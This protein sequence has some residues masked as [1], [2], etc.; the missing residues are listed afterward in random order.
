MQHC[1]IGKELSAQWHWCIYMYL[2]TSQKWVKESCWD[3]QQQ[4]Y[5]SF[6]Y[7]LIWIDNAWFY[8]MLIHWLKSRRNDPVPRFLLQ[9][10]FLYSARSRPKVLLWKPYYV[11]LRTHHECERNEWKHLWKSLDQETWLDWG[12]GILFSRVGSFGGSD[13][14]WWSVD[15]FVVSWVFWPGFLDDEF[16]KL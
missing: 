3:V 1:T 7:L 5:Q 6:F 8:L 11:E 16:V 10:L 4:I 15:D 9:M 2:V 13:V 12:A 14:M